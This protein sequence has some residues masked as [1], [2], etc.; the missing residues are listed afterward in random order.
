MY[1]L[2]EMV[3][4]VSNRIQKS[5]ATF[6]SHIKEWIDERYDEIWNKIRWP[7][8]LVSKETGINFVASQGHLILPKDVDT[9]EV[10]AERSNDHVLFPKS[11]AGMWRS[12]AANMDNA[13]KPINYAPDGEVQYSNQPSS[14]EKLSVVSSAVSGD[15][16]QTVRL[17]YL[18][19]G[20]ITY[21]DISLN[22]DTPVVSSG[23]CD[24]S[25]VISISKSASTTGTITVSG[26]S[27]ATVFGTLGQKEYTAYY[28]RLRLR[29]IPDANDTLT[30]IYAKRRDLLLDDNDVPAIPCQTALIR[31]AYSDAL[32]EQ[33]QKQKSMVEDAKF[34]QL[35]D[36]LIDK[37][38]LQGE[39]FD[40]TIPHVE[41]RGLNVG[42]GSYRHQLGDT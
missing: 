11:L 18:V 15:N 1:T 33:K 9:I 7:Q 27:S 22:N 38:E 8:A 34:N 28:K 32:A 36:D 30:V 16:T 39:Q 14:A 5:D 35:V 24:A 37:A 10:L 17:K 29:S 4:R 42:Q 6:Q 3:S 20:E 26:N 19:N 40:Q 12:S 23:T 13:G 2:G 21:E 41:Q 31:G 25:G